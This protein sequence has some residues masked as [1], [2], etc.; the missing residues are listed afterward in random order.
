MWWGS[1]T[2]EQ[3]VHTELFFIPAFLCT[4]CTHLLMLCLAIIGSYLALTTPWGGPPQKKDKFVCHHVIKYVNLW[5]MW[6]KLS[7]AVI[8]CN[9]SKWAG[10]SSPFC[11][12]GYIHISPVQFTRSSGTKNWAR[13]SCLD[14]YDGMYSP[15][16][17]SSFSGDVYFLSLWIISGVLYALVSAGNKSSSQGGRPDHLT[18]VCR[19]LD[20]F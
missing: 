5:N 15:V 13:Q 4:K 11:L 14:I 12:L 9:G 3:T 1:L 16:F 10:S 19:I 17:L 18:G 8:Y 7:I 6:R 20:H 2:A